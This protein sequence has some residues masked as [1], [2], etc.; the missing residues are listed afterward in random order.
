ML[1]HA[2]FL[3]FLLVL[4]AFFSAS[5]TA[6][7]SLSVMQINEM[8]KKRA[9]RGKIVKQLTERPEIL[10]TTILIGNNLVNIGASALATDITIRLFGSRAI[11][12]STGILTLV[13]LIFSEVTPKRIAIV[14]NDFIAANTAHVVLGLSWLLRPIIW[15]VTLF[16][17]LFTRLISRKPSSKI[18][19]DGIIHVVNLARDAGIVKDYQDR[20]VKSV[21]RFNETPVEAIMTHRTGV[22]SL[23]ANKKIA[24]VLELVNE[25]GYSRIPVFDGHPEK[26]VGIVLAKD[27]MDRV[28]H[29]KSELKLKEI[30]LK[31]LFVSES[32]KVSEL[33]WQFKKARLNLAVV[34]DEYGGL[35]GIVTQEDVVEE[36]FGELYDED[37]EKGWEKITPLPDGC[38]R[39][40]GDTSIGIVRDLLGME[41]PHGKYVQTIAGYI[42][43]KLDRF[44]VD[45]ETLE[46]PEGKLVVESVYKNRIRSVRYIPKKAK[47]QRK[48]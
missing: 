39:I 18:S 30:M 10:L 35:A 31:P 29:G 44:A 48:T 21:F 3:L 45:R 27:L 34:M 15:F 47:E 5:E 37:E 38:F 4:S 36:L 41:L 6:F 2:L 16:S 25:E 43:E 23:D 20:M 19:L 28:I 24:D 11:G 17:T 46:I 22:F 1:G 32:R 14:Y 42:I 7:T 12:I 26:I 40:M 8:E 33:F 13:V 9:R